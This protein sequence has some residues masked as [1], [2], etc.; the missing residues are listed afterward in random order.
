M[1]LKG[2]YERG[3]GRKRGAERQA[4]FFFFS[5]SHSSPVSSK[6]VQFLVSIRISNPVIVSLNDLGKL[7]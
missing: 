1:E 2:S 6:V 7:L 5:E 4:F 3:M